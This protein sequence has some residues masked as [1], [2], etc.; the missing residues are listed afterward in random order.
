VSFRLPLDHVVVLVA[1]LPGV[2]AAFA[3]A[4]FQVSPEA[5][6]SAEM[7]TANRCVMLDGTYVEILGIVAETP[8]NA[9]W[10]RLLALG[11]GVRGIALR[12]LDIGATISATQ[13]QGLSVEPVRH[14]SRATAEGS[15]RF[16]V[17]RIDLAETPGVQC[18]FCQHHTAGLLWRPETMR[19]ANGVSRLTQLAFPEAASLSRLSG[20]AGVPV[21]AGASRLT[22]SGESPARHDLKTVCGIEL[23]VVAS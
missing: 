21:V 14:F 3:A 22:F 10:R 6:H 19:H 18:L 12:S 7:G 9:A 2:S 1:D 4:G 8:A 16:S 5:R 11:A 15:L 17:A 20:E 13:A 23:E